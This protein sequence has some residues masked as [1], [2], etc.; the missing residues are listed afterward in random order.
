MVVVVSETNLRI[1]VLLSR[2]QWLVAIVAV[3]VL[4][5]GLWFTYGAYAAEPE[6]IEEDRLVNTWSVT[7]EFAH[8]AT[9]EEENE[10]FAVGDRLENEPLYY[11]SLSPTADG[12]YVAGYE[13]TEGEDVT[14]SIDVELVYR[15]VDDDHEYWRETESLAEVTE[16]AVPADEPVNATFSLEVTELD[17]RV[18]EIEASLGASPGT[19]ET[20]LVAHV[21]YV[22]TFEG[23][24]Q[25][26]T[27][28]S[29]I[30]VD[31][32]GGTYSFEGGEFSV[33]DEVFETVSVEQSPDTLEA[34]GGPIAA[35]VG[36][37]LL[38]GLGLFR[39]RDLEPTQAEREWLAYR[40]AYADLESLI[41][42]IDLP[43]EVLDR[44]R[45]GVS[46]LEDLSELALDVG[47]A[48]VHDETR[49]Q[50]LV[51]D[52]DVI[53]V[54][55]PPAEPTA[56]DDDPLPSTDPEPTEA[57][58]TEPEP[59]TDEAGA[60]DSDVVTFDDDAVSSSEASTA[61]L[62]RTDDE[63]GEEADEPSSPA[64]AGNRDGSEDD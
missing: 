45:A 12:A 62:E 5:G 10:L 47:S 59:T 18:D 13:R 51:R 11:T 7:G 36:A 25:T 50:Y 14:I 42:R 41:T 56:S 21:E 44:P 3:L 35:L 30:D 53:Y 61:S 9:V 39:H 43:E 38:A 24:P 57:E 1:R 17:E 48:I 26:I 23:E 2:Y 22:G 33:D 4:F 32:G 52:S 63:T 8:A 55:T 64:D 54:Y 19:T 27:E 29:E 40:R 34:V 46:S 20:V 6:S 28:T 60:A 15:A 16:E 49:G 31:A 37:G 58:A